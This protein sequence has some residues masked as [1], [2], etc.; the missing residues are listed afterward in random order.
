M[1][2]EILQLRARLAL[3]THVTLSPAGSPTSP[4]PAMISD[5]LSNSPEL[6]QDIYDSLTKAMNSTIEEINTVNIQNRDRYILS[7]NVFT[8]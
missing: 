8:S 5:F 1:L 2:S 3:H 4:S 6:L 7:K